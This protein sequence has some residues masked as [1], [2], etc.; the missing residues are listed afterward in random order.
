MA[1]V[2]FRDNIFVATDAAPGRYAEVVELVRNILEGAWGLLVVCDCSTDT[3]LSCTSSCCVL[4]CK[5]MGTVLVRGSGGSGMAFVE[6]SSVNAQW[7]LILDAPLLSPHSKY[8]GYMGS[9]VT[10]VLK[11]GVPFLLLGRPR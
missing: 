7:K 1:M 4:V 9:I 3:Q 11:N 5:A 2:Q 10:G 6:P 8:P